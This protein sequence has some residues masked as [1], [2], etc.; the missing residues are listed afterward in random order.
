MLDNFFAKLPTDL[1]AEVFE[2]LAG[3]NTV[4]IERIVSNG[5]YTQ[6]T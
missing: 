1:S 4:T 2:K 6:A 5:Q 3:N